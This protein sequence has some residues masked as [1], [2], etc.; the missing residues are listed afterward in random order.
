MAGT[1]HL[2][3]Y[4]SLTPEFGGTRFGPF[5]GLEVRLGSDNNRCHIVLPES[6]G[7]L[8]EHVK[9]IRQGPVNLILAP[10][11]RTATVFLYKQSERRPLQLNTP[12]AVRPGDA[13]T[14][15]TPDGPRFVVE[16]GELPDEIKAQR[17]GKGGPFGG[18][19]IGGRRIPDA[20]A[21]KQEGKRQVWTTLLTTG[22]GQLF[23]RAYTYI[24]SGA[25]FQP[26]N[27]I[28]MVMFLAAGGGLGL[29]RCNIKK[30]RRQNQNFSE[31]VASCQQDLVFAD[32][33]G[34][35]STK[36]NFEQL[37]ASILSSVT[38]GNALQEDKKLRD[39]I[40]QKAR[41]IDTSKYDW[42][43]SVKGTQAQKLTTWRK[44][45]MDPSSG[46]DPD[47][48]WLLTW[49][50]V[51]PGMGRDKFNVFVDSAGD[52]VC[53][54]GMLQMTFRQSLRLSVTSQPDAYY[55]G[56]ATDL[57]SDSAMAAHVKSRLK[58]PG[59]PLDD[60]DEG[61]YRVESVNSRKQCVYRDGT[62]DRENINKLLAQ[63]RRML[64]EKGALLP[65]PDKAWGSVARI[66]KV[67]AA[68]IPEIDY[69]ERN[70]E[71]IDFS[72][73]HVSTTL[74]DFGGKGDWVLEQTAEAVARAIVLPCLAVL[75]G[76][77]AKV[78]NMLGENLPTEIECLVMDYR[79][80][81][82]GS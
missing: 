62:D 56:A 13:F 55:L 79:L 15:V 64:G 3:T 76:D 22:P 41:E 54:R 20:D 49:A 70:E 34:G 69:N 4:L 14:L 50:G 67:Y 42:V 51:H 23:Q 33:L 52:E 28:M 66:A 53:G 45:L 26:R 35:D 59:F 78:T 57:D 74:A 8:P 36:Y 18:R 72:A 61:T 24:V 39:L 25:I 40:K 9:L 71:G 43:A 44:K 80:R 17:E 48:A 1:D 29:Q 19:R 73:N 27:I 32:S 12:T 75:Q 6:L 47:T 10:A 60:L 81:N 16:V 2:V 65:P 7:V 37:A 5:E 11:E 31:Q 82:D 77:E 46:L 63:M 38:L 21:F 30:L 68:D 58:V